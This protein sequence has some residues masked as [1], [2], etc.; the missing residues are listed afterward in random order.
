MLGGGAISAAGDFSLR[1]QTDKFTEGT[2]RTVAVFNPF[3]GFGFSAAGGFNLWRRKSRC[4][5]N[6]KNLS[7]MPLCPTP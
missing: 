5:S 3:S 7:L 4:S 1:L 6:M 2:R